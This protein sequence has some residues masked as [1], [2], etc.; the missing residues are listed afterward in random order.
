MVYDSG[1]DH[2]ALFI[3]VAAA[4]NLLPFPVQKGAESVEVLAVDDFSVISI[5]QRSNAELYFNLLFD[6]GDES[7]LDAG[8]TEN[9]IR[10]HAGL[11]A[12]EV[13]SPDDTLCRKGNFCGP[14]DNTGALSA[15][16]QNGRS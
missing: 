15:K 11:T 16:F 10:S 13:F 6:L 1:A 12:V 3:R 5:P 9:I 2:Q 4:D 7:V 8:I 14:V